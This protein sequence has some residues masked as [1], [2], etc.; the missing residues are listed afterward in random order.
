M[1]SIKQ[2]FFLPIS[3]L[4]LTSFTNRRTTS[5]SFDGKA[6]NSKEQRDFSSSTEEEIK[7]YYNYD[8]VSHQKGQ[9][10]KKS[11]YDIIS[12][13]NTFVSYSSSSGKGVG[14]WYKITDRNWEL[15]RKID[16]ATYRF[17][18]DDAIVDGKPVLY[19]TRMYFEDTTTES[20]QINGNVNSFTKNAAITAIDWSKKECPSAKSSL[21]NTI[22]MDKE[23]VWVKSH[24]FPPQKNRDPV[25][26][27]GTDLHHLRAADHATNNAHN[28]LY[29][30]EVKDHAQAKTI[31]C[32]YADGTREVSGW[33]G[34]T[35]QG[36]KCFEPT[37]RWKGDVARALL[38][39]GVRYS[40]YKD[41]NTEAEPYL[42]L[43]DDITKQDD[44]EHY[45]GVFHNLSTF[46]KWNKED[47]PD[48][49]EKKRNDRIYKNVQN[50][51]N[52]FVDFP[53][54]A[55]L[56][57][58]SSDPGEKPGEGG[59]SE[60]PSASTETP[61]TPGTSASSGQT[62]QESPSV[63]EEKPSDADSSLT[64][65]STSDSGGKLEFNGLFGL[66]KS[67]TLIL[68]AVASIVL[69]LVAITIVLIRQKKKPKK[70]KPSYNKR[71]NSKNKK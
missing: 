13:D 43:T 30:G 67:Q 5:A 15:S 9:T 22:Q 28:D 8:V 34:N 42:E 35:E 33:I 7:S 53:D 52:P 63:P 1:K 16:S 69:V 2:F 64:N 29:Y 31:Y 61:S 48:T 6:Y 21:G 32:I 36:E 12:K 3:C 41:T 46:L 59:G 66:S 58:D 20:K 26:G 44:N 56:V 37:D 25:K 71:R 47:K 49:Y 39:R 65:S 68:V 11:L 19:E 4:L 14:T 51:R 62:S 55:D 57:Y 45:H 18:D 38:Y 70:K 17:A 50:N 10:R 27:A 24:G 54:W 60:N 40:N 23:H